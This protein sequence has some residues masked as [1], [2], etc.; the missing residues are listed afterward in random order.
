MSNVNC[1]PRRFL[2]F[3]LAGFLVA[4]VL[5]GHAAPP[6][7]PDAKTLLK[8]SDQFRNGWPSFVVHVRITDFAAGKPDEEHLYEVSQ[9]GTDK[10]YVEFL[11]AREKGE[12]LLMLGDDMWIYLPDTSRPVRITPLERLTGD[13]SNGDIARTNYAADYS[14]VYL[15]T[16]KVGTVDCHVLDLTAKRKGA[17]YQT[18]VYWL[19]VQDARPVKADFYLT[20]GKHIKS[21]TFDEYEQ[22]D[23]Q[24][25]LRR[26]TLYD[27]ILHNSHS[28]L[29]YS[30]ATPRTLPDK[31][32]YQGRA[33]KF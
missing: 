13:T 15:H 25:L 23:G 18:I 28:V 9:K 3:V 24:M 11:S 12:H 20:S 26:L 6:A 30:D 32:F 14:P 10:T 2:L 8:Q 1:S 4:C 19:R 16:E 5:Q 33:D 7:T 22:T 31:L 21:A 29:E 17:T 27:E